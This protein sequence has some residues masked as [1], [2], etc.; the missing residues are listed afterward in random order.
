MILSYDFR[1]HAAKSASLAQLS[2]LLA[3]LLQLL[4]P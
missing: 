4:P 3:H 2:A 1:C